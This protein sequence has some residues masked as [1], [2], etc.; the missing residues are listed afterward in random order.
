M[1]LCDE[2]DTYVDRILTKSVPLL[3]R[4]LPHRGRSPLIERSSWTKRSEVPRRRQA[5]SVLQG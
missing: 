1:F 3:T 2:T 4:V 5:S